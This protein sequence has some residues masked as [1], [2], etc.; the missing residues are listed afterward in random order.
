VLWWPAAQ[1]FCSRP[2]A[3][4]SALRRILEHLKG[5]LHVDGYAGFERLT[6]NDEVVLAACWAHTRRKFYEIAEADGAP[7]ALEALRRIGDLYAIEAQIRGQSPAHRLATRRSQSKPIVD[8]LYIWLEIQLPL[9]PA[10]SKLAEALQYALSRWDGLTRFLH[11][12]RIELDTTLSNAQSVRWRSVARIT[13]LRAAT[14]AVCAGRS[15][16]R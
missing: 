4:P 7:L 14:E 10:R 12:G 15:S 13:C 16:A 1:S 9:L 8:S 2:T 5:V 6:A 11:D 3:K